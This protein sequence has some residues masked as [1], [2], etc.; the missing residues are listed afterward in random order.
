M[1]QKLI[2]MNIRKLIKEEIQKLFEQDTVE[3]KSKSDKGNR[4]FDMLKTAE[5]QHYDSPKGELSPFYK[6]EEDRKRLVSKLSDADK[7]TYREWLKTTEGQAS[8]E[9]FAEFCT[10]NDDTKLVNEAKKSRFERLKD[11]K[12]P[13]TDEERKKVMDAEAVWHFSPGNK[14][15]PAVWKSKNSAGKITYVTNTHRAY[16]D[17]P[18]LKGAISIF[19]SF[20]KSTA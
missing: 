14:P 8:I 3:L 4:Y 20:I 1:L 13:L 6:G 12:I 10:V 17:R 15:T 7:K 2:K 18:T 16:Q 9:K 5:F 11:N 19:H